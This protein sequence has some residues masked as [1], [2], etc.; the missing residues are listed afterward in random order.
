MEVTPAFYTASGEAIVGDNFQLQPSE[1][2]FV[3]IESLIPEHHR[4]QHLWGG[5]SL[6]YFGR[7]LEVWAQI[8]L[9]GPNGIATLT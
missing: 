9:R 8:T 3:T 6:S 1:M 2:R 7:S 4:G 5:M